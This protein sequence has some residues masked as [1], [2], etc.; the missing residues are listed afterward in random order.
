VYSAGMID[1]IALKLGMPPSL[2]PSGAGGGQ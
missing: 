2:S 1:A